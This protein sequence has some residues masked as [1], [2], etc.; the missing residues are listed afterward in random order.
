VPLFQVLELEGFQHGLFP[1]SDAAGK[2]FQQAT[3]PSAKPEL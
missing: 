3:R 1:R 2:F